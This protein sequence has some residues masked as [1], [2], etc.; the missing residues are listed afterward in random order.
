MTILAML[1]TS[2][3]VGWLFLIVKNCQNVNKAPLVINFAFMWG[4][5]LISRKIPFIPMLTMDMAMITLTIVVMM[6][7]RKV[8]A[9]TK[10]ERIIL[11]D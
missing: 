5:G 10:L 6:W 9:G 3:I 8:L 2:S 7:I 11:N 1:Q 4:Y